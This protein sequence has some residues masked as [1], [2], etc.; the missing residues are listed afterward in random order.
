ML[1]LF[2]LLRDIHTCLGKA[3]NGRCTV[4]K[5]LLV[6]PHPSIFPA[7]HSS[8]YHSLCV[9]HTL[10]SLSLSHSLSIYQLQDRESTVSLLVGAQYGVSQVIN[11]KLSI[12]TTLTEF[13]C[14][15][16]VELLPE[17]DRVSLVKIYLQDIK[18]YNT[19]HTHTHIYICVQFFHSLSLILSHFSCLQPITLLM[20]SVAAKDLLCLVAGY[21]RLLVDPQISVFPWSDNSKSH[22][23]SAE[24]G[25]ELLNYLVKDLVKID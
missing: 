16:R 17:S 19:V 10:L 12:M 24:E 21:C 2:I 6:Y 22:R 5:I 8:P 13:S 9:S 11:H 15:T 4:L 3:R 23:I 25:T 18:V 14:I 20:E 1:R 7:V